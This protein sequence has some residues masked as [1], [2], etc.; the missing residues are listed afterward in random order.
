MKKDET[1]LRGKVRPSFFFSCLLPTSASIG[2][3][4]R[5]Q[6]EVEL[7]KAMEGKIVDT[8]DLSHDLETEL[9]KLVRLSKRAAPRSFSLTPGQ[10][11]KARSVFSGRCSGM[12]TAFGLTLIRLGRPP[13]QIHPQGAGCNL[14]ADGGGVLLSR[15]EQHRRNRSRDC[16]PVRS[17]SGSTGPLAG[18]VSPTA[19]PSTAR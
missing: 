9:H 17:A 5:V 12:N 8:I 19:N 15:H 11:A 1:D 7:I 10:T 2:H 18:G 16:K 4:G 14:A 13:A 6:R 3:S